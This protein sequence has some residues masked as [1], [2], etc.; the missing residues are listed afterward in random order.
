MSFHLSV[1]KISVALII[2]RP[3]IQYSFRQLLKNHPNITVSEQCDNGLQGVRLLK[4]TSADIVI[5]DASLEGVDVYE[6]IA[7]FSR[8]RG[9][10]DK[11]RIIIHLDDRKQNNSNI[12]RYI[13]SGVSAIISPAQSIEDIVASIN[14]VSRGGYHIP[15]EFTQDCDFLHVGTNNIDINL[16]S[17]EQQ[18]LKLVIEGYKSRNIAEYLS[19][20][21]KTVECHRANL[22]RKFNVNNVVDLINKSQLIGF[23]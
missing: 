22:R 21:I 2:S 9:N 14:N 23:C 13:K 8:G 3:I 6:M 10:E 7:Q 19:L 1:Q 11:T 5:I 18:V 16:S 17:R 4:R 20:S 15:P 12:I